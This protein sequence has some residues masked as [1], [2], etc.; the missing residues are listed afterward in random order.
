MS[1]STRLQKHMVAAAAVAAGVAGTASAAVNYSGLVN[2]AVP[3]TFYGLYVNTETG[4]FASNAPGAG[5]PGWDINPYG[6]ADL[7][8]W[9]PANGGMMRYSSTSATTCGSLD[10]GQVVSAAGLFVQTTAAVTFGG[11]AGQWKV[12]SINYFGFRMTTAANDGFHY[13]FGRMQ[14]GATATSR[15]LLDWYW[16][17][18]AGTAITVPGPGAAALMG[19]AGVM[20]RRRRR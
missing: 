10:V 12:N 14:V 3:A 11:A 20:G 7:R 18:T 17:G 16:E 9:C 13:A 1:L 4:A 19:L 15:T 6:S 8:M 5:V 2:L